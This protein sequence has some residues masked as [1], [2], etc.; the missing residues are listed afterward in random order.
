MDITTLVKNPLD[1]V[2]DVNHLPISFYE[3]LN[4]DTLY[5][6]SAHYLYGKPYIYIFNAGKMS[7]VAEVIQV[8]Y[9]NID[10]M[11]QRLLDLHKQL[12]N[13]IF[14]IPRMREDLYIID[15]LRCS[16]WCVK[17]S[18][19]DVKDMTSEHFF[20]HFGYNW[21]SVWQYVKDLEFEKLSER[22]PDLFRSE[23]IVR[24]I[25]LLRET[26]ELTDGVI[27]FSAGIKFLMDG[28]RKSSF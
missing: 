3:E 14:H 24:E 28:N 23:R 26:G 4:D 6:I 19:Q 10:R 8:D 20:H 9:V 16:N 5:L 22:F 2:N 7:L 15:S 27:S 13:S 18:F 1:S 25:L 17:L 21:D 12:K 11:I